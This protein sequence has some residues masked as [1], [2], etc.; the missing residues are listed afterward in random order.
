MDVRRS[1]LETWEVK[2]NDLPEG[3]PIKELTFEQLQEIINDIEGWVYPRRNISAFFSLFPKG[4]KAA[5]SFYIMAA[6]GMVIAG[7]ILPFLSGSWWWFL[8]A[9]GAVL[10][11]KANRKSMEQFFLENLQDNGG[12]Y[13]AIRGVESLRGADLL[14]AFGVGG[15]ET[16]SICH[17]L[18]T[19]LAWVLDQPGFTMVE[20]TVSG[21]EPARGGLGFADELKMEIALHMDPLA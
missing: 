3:T 12:F 21:D 4:Q 16:L 18:C 20:M 13:D 8:L 19:D 11:W 5:L 6:I 2:M 7:I 1:Y 15:T 10:L 17:R 9:P 14:V